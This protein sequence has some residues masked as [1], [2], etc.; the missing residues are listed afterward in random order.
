[1]SSGSTLK[2]G[3]V[4]SINAQGA[5]ESFRCGPQGGEAFEN[6]SLG[7]SNERSQKNAPNGGYQ[8]YDGYTYF[9]SQST[10]SVRAC[11]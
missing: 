8:P 11:I 1:M 10:D 9:G 4:L 5:I 3:E 7:F 6:N 2:T